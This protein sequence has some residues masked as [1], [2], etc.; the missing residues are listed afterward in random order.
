M[1]RFSAVRRD[2]AGEGETP[3]DEFAHLYEHFGVE[4]EDPDDAEELLAAGPCTLVSYC[5]SVPETSR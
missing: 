4:D 5:R 3:D 2:S 1:R